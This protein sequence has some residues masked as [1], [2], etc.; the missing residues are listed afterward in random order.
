VA[1]R[2]GDRRPVDRHLP[3]TTT[4]TAPRRRSA[5]AA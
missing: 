3:A 2:M 1:A 5:R 4:P